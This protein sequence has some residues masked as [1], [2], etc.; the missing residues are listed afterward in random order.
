MLR[1]G[2]FDA[3]QHNA[4]LGAISL[5]EPP[6]IDHGHCDRLPAAALAARQPQILI[7]P[8]QQTPGLVP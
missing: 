2:K 1:C 8:L 3:V 4:K 7:G 6:W 5:I